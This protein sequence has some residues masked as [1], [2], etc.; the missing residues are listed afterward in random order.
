[1]AFGGVLKSENEGET[2]LINKDFHDKSRVR[3]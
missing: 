3:E 1:M 2:K